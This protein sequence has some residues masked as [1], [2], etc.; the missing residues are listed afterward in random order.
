MPY[1]RLRFANAADVQIDIGGV[2]YP[3][4]E[5]DKDVWTVD[6]PLDSG[7]LLCAACTWTTAWC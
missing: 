3:F 7:L 1:L 4:L 2:R 6:L 5:T